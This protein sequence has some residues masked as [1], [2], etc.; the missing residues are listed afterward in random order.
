MGRVVAFFVFLALCWLVPCHRAQCFLKAFLIVIAAKHA[1]GGDL[2]V[3]RGPFE[4]I[5]ERF[6]PLNL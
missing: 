1:R 6:D 5:N 4:F 2:R 3:G